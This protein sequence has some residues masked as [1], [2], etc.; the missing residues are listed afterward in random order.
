[1]NELQKKIFYKKILPKLILLALFIIG[2]IIVIGVF[3]YNHY[4][5][6][7]N[8]EYFLEQKAKENGKK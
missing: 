5:E 6:K 1:M 4:L 7:K 2:S 3:Q 8:R